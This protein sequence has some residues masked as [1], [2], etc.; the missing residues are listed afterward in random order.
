MEF[1][2]RSTQDFDFH[3]DEN[4]SVYWVLNLEHTTHFFA[5]RYI[6]IVRGKM[7]AAA[8]VRASILPGSYSAQRYDNNN[9][10]HGGETTLLSDDDCIQGHH[11]HESSLRPVSNTATSL[12]ANPASLPMTSPLQQE[13]GNNYQVNRTTYNTLPTH[14]V[15]IVPKG[16]LVNYG[17]R[18]KIFLGTFV[19]FMVV[20]TV[21]SRFIN[22]LLS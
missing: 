15:M 13:R 20:A 4:G 6:D 22:A 11:E 2:V 7:Q 12:S 19:L 17:L 5:N 10:S 18:L 8:A 9:K 14:K 1:R 21:F 3:L 16:S